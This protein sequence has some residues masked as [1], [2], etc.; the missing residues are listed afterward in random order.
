MKLVEFG[1][2]EAASNAV[3]NQI[4]KALDAHLAQAPKAGLI[5]S[6]GTTPARCFRLLAAK[7]LPW[8]RVFVSLTDERDVPADDPLSNENLVRANLLQGCAARAEFVAPRE[9]AM[10]KLP[11][12][13]A[14]TLLGMGEDGHF[15]SLFPAM[16]GL[17]SLL[18]PAGG[19]PGAWVETPATPTRRYTLAMRT[20]ANTNNLVL[21]AFGEAK[22]QVLL[23]Q[24]EAL[25]VHTLADY[26]GDVLTVCWAP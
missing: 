13:F 8:Q 3:A 15:A 25:P 1:T 21:L 6:G 23:E 2:R 5:V 20:L 7:S 22:R 11:R 4:K 26:A 17:A 18:A 9:L 24:D 12:P 10:G 14:F 16:E 19:P